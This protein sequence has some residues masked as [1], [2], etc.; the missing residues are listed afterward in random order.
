MERRINTKPLALPRSRRRDEWRGLTS[1]RAGQIVPIAFFP[2]L[3]EDRMRGRIDVVVRMAEALHTI[4]N[5]IRVRMSAH[6]IPKSALARFDGSLEVLNRSYMGQTLPGGAA[7]P[8]WEVADPSV[9]T[10]GDDDLGHEIYDKLGIHYKSTTAI[11]SDLIESYWTMVNWRRAAVSKALPPVAITETKLAPAFWD[12]TKFRAVKASF[13][14]AMME[15]NVP[16]AVDGGYLPVTGIGFA[17]NPAPSGVVAGTS[18]R[19]TGG[20]TQQGDSYAAGLMQ[21]ATPGQAQLRVIEDGKNRGYPEIYA[22][23]GAADATISLANIA[24][25]TQTRRMAELR[26]QYQGIPDEYLIDMLMQ[27]LSVPPEDFR[28]PV[29]IAMQETTI[30]QVERYATDG[31]S[32]DQSVTRGMAMLSAPLNTP[33]VPTGGMV[34]VTI[35]IV[36]QQLYERIADKALAVKT[37]DELPDALR[38]MLDP[39]KVEVVPNSYADSFHSVPNGVFG[40][41]P[42][43][44][45]WQR[46][47]ARVG[48]RF[49]RPVPDAFVE[50]RQRIWAVEKSDPALSADFYLCPDPFPHTVFADADADPFEVTT[51]GSAV[52]TGLTQFGPGFEE[53]DDHY[54]KI[55]A[56]VDLTRIDQGSTQAVRSDSAEGDD[57]SG[58]DEADVGVE[59]TPTAPGRKAR[60]ADAG[61]QASVDGGVA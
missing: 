30:G 47:F 1:C 60:G 5:P 59:S 38:D 28:E 40:Y 57:A 50:D 44:F 20:K 17:G 10:F 25:A 49:K 16:V 11:N 45:Q 52:M 23:M 35:E 33:A 41:A 24:T 13:D 21:A 34:L 4:I 54:E 22:E 18:I 26:Q 53:D 58:D 55:M 36:P 37:P 61:A 7:A 8:A 56:Q 12:A 46:S 29:L 19:V 14:A 3:R 51:V 48:G 27:G 15:G 32:L 42:L 9:A 43:N 2:L 39:Q 6:L 31:A